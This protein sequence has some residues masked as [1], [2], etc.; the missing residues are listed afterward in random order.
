MF[1]QP[2]AIPRLG[3]SAGFSMYLLDQSGSGIDALKLPPRQRERVFHG[4]ALEWLGLEVES[5]LNQQSTAEISC[6]SARVR[7]FVLA[8]NEELEMA[9]LVASLLV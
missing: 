8:I 9:D 1:M 4:A 5:N 6:K 2:P 3:N 7:T